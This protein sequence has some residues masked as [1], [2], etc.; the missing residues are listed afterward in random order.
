MICRILLFT[1]WDG[2]YESSINI[3]EE[4]LEII[5]NITSNGQKMLRIYQILMVTIY[6]F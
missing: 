5:A 3:L 6:L 2:S 1:L 4:N